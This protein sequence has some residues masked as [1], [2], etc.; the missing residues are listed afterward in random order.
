MSAPSTG[1]LLQEGL[2]LHRRGAV[3]EAAARY[4]DVLRIRPTPTRFIIWR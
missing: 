1:E 2:T 3:D 4:H